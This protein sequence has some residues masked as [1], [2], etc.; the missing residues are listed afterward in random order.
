MTK[1]KYQYDT[2][3]EIPEDR[4]DLY[5]EQGGKYLFTGVEGIKTQ[6]DVDNVKA[7]ADKE[8][9]LRADLESKLKKF[10]A[11]GDRDPSELLAQLDEIESLRAQLAEG[12]KPANEEQ[13][14]KRVTAAV[15]TK[16]SQFKRDLDKIVAERDTFAKR[17][18]ELDS[19]LKQGT[20]R[21]ALLDA[22]SKGGVDPLAFE[23]VLARSSLFE[24]GDDGKPVTRDGVGVTPG[25]SPDAWLA[26]VLPTKPHWG[27]NAV[28]AGLQGSSGGRAPGP[29][30]FKKDAFN[31][32]ACVEASNRDPSKAE[33]L[34]KQ[35]GF[36]SV[37]DAM[38]WAG[39]Q[40][41][42]FR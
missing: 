30:P 3:D 7:A 29:N 28:G 34:A 18:A 16:E 41:V 27:K 5:E 23:D 25:L 14:Q 6:R 8:R 11:L 36:S 15:V 33:A 24:I 40:G 4:R 26:E 12:G 35:A 2:I 32:S 31:L 1:L 42:K 17:A 37:A 19:T 10:G 21:N 20:L 9:K 38:G 39:K 22:A 13:I